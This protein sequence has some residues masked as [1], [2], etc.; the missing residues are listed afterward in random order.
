MKA[1]KYL[2]N[3][4]NKY[5]INEFLYSYYTV[6]TTLQHARTE[7]IMAC[8]T[9]NFQYIYTREVQKKFKIIKFLYR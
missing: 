6:Y 5:S 7:Y 9:V 1:R 8:K 3:I 2:P 4:K